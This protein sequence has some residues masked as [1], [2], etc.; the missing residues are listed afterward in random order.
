MTTLADLQ[1]AF[2]AGRATPI[3]VAETFL[4]ADPVDGPLAA[5]RAVHAD[6][7]IDQARA[8][9]ERH[10]AGNA[11]GPLDG[12]LVAVKDAVAVAGYRTL[13]GTRELAYHDPARDGAV[14]AT[15]VRRLRDAGAVIAGKTHTTELG[16]SPTGTSGAQPTP[17]NPHDLSRLTGGSSSGTGAA[18]AAGLTTVGVGSD[19]GGSIRIPAAVCGVFGIKPSWG[20]VPG[21]GTAP[22]GWWS[23]DHLGPLA[24]CADDLA[25]VLGVL[26]DRR[27]DVVDRPLRYGVDWAW[28][29]Q[30]DPAVDAPCRAA[31]AELSPTPVTIPGIEL[32]RTAGYATALS[33]LTAGIWETLRDR[34]EAFS[35]DIR[36]AV[37]QAANISGADYLRAQQV[38]QLLADGL[39][40][41]FDDVDVLLVPTVALP[42]PP[43]PSDA[44]LAEGVLDTDLIDA[45]TAYTFPANLCGLPA[46]SVPVGVTP[47]TGPGSG[48]PIGLQVVGRRGD[49]ATVLAA[50][51]ALERAGLAVRP[52]PRS[53]HATLSDL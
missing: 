2:A 47:G 4:A 25:T 13:A 16:L 32:A 11:I 27:Y 5:F 43:R 36:T 28:W 17:R 12:V 3:G 21:D 46:A 15:L 40:R 23:L 42:A 33:E 29:G 48:L 44:D 20:V 35:A 24:R 30:P 6:D 10:A 34:P 41:A 52:R 31:A 9:T 1:D 7:V 49:D 51:A 45:M 26:A 38:R 18:V 39:D 14:E 19:G 8:A 22:V 53:E 50:C 37:A